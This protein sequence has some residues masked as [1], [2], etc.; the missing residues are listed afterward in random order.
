MVVALSYILAVLITVALAIFLYPIA[1]MFW[2]FGLLG[3][4][5]EGLFSFTKKTIAALW[6]DLKNSEQ[7]TIVSTVSAI[8]NP[9]SWVCSCGCSNLGKFCS[10]C[11][12]VKPNNT[13]VIEE[14]E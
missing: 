2:V 8:D 4:L 3:K 13:V 11:G 10:E 7:V 9:N 14:A 12:A 6:R 1:A 5:S